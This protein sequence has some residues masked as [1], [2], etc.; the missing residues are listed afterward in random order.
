MGKLGKI[1]RRVFL[2]GAVAVT[3]GVAVGAY[4]VTRDPKNPLKPDEGASLNSYVIIDQDGVTVIVP[5]AEMGQGVQTS[6]AAL[7]AEE[8]EVP[9][10]MVRVEH[11]PPAKAYANNK[12]LLPRGYDA[13]PPMKMVNTVMEAMPRMLGM[14][15]TGGSMSTVDA[16]DK[17]RIAGAAAREM[18]I[19]AAAERLGVGRDQL[20]AENGAIVATDGTRLPYAELA[21]AAATMTPP[22]NPPLKDPAD[23]K[24]IGKPLPKLD[25]PAKATGTAPF[26][27]D[28]RADGMKFATVK[29]APRIEGEMVSYDASEAEGMAGVEKIIDLGDGVAVVAS[30]T[31]LAIQA[32]EA[33][34]FEWGPAPYGATTDEIFADLEAAF[35]TE[36]NITPHDHGEVTES[37]DDLVAEYRAPFLSHAPMEPMNA[38]ALYTGD[39]LEIWAGVQ[40]PIITQQQAAE[41]V[42]LKQDQVTLHT[43]IMGGSFGR[44]GFNEYAIYA[45][46]VAKEM[47]GTPVNVTWS[48]EEDMRHDHYRPGAIARMRGRLDGDRIDTFKA[49][50]S[51]ASV[52]R[53]TMKA[54]MGIDRQTADAMITE[55]VAEQPYGFPNVLIRGYVPERT[56]RVGFWR[57]VGNSQN[58]FFM[59]SFIDELAHKAGADPLAFRL[60]HIEGTDAETAEVLRTV[61]DMANWT[62]ETPEGKGRG[63]AVT[64]SFG[65]PV[66]EIIEVSDQDGAVKIDKVWI[67]A[68]LGKIVDPG[69]VEAQLISGAIYGLSAAML[70]EITF[71]DG[72]VVEG[73]FWDHDALRMNNTPD[74]EVTALALGGAVGGVGEPGTPP[75]AAALANA[76]YDLNGTRLRRMPFRHDIDFVT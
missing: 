41:A 60:A 67:A 7:V 49:D 5:R 4:A 59:E 35:D 53:A 39:R 36:P 52:M 74:F 76:I 71:E 27:I 43:T 72:K 40:G 50:L 61:R 22:D 23:W 30:N 24:L 20:R 26:G 48:R 1:T 55:G 73:N 31:W 14:Q 21:E 2:V 54:F 63:V 10:D 13:E 45:A 15:I 17:N 12:F 11:G 3:G 34:R 47:E 65:T 62:G 58:A 42:G 32:A 68:D 8:L 38:T 18:L 51:A 56:P 46:R 69:N 25:Q 19:S 28:T 44:R 75:A 70:E 66:A 64:Y 16:W 33:I 57:S 29:M 6:L 9:M 37:D